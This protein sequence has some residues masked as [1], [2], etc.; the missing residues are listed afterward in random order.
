MEG[1]AAIFFCPGTGGVLEQ[2]P[3]SMA[4]ASDVIS[5]CALDAAARCSEGDRKRRQ[6]MVPLHHA[7]LASRRATQRERRK[8]LHDGFSPAESRESLLLRAKALAHDLHHSTRPDDLLAGSRAA[9]PRRDRGASWKCWNPISMLQASFD[10]KR[11]LRDI[12]KARKAAHGH[13]QKIRNCIAQTYT[14]LQDEQLKSVCGDDGTGA[15]TPDWMVVQHLWD[16]T[17]FNVKCETVGSHSVI[18][19][20]GC[21]FWSDSAGVDHRQE[22]IYAPCVVEDTTAD[23]LFAALS[24]RQLV[25][26]DQLASGAHLVC[27]QPIADSVSANI[28]VVKWMNEVLAPGVLILWGRC[29]QHQCAIAL[30][31]M[32]KYLNIV[33][34]MFCVVKIFYSGQHMRELLKAIEAVIDKRFEWVIDGA[35][36]Q[37]DLSRVK[38]LCAVCHMDIF[39]GSD[40]D[41]NGVKTRECDDICAMVTGD[42]RS[43]KKIS[44]HCRGCCR[45]RD[46]ALAKTVAA[47]TAPLKR[48]MHTPAIN[49][50]GTVAPVVAT[51]LLLLSLHGIIAQAEMYLIGQCPENYAPEES[52]DADDEND[53]REQR[54]GGDMSMASH[55]RQGRRRLKRARE[56][57]C[58]TLTMRNL[59]IWC[60]IGQQAMRLH[61]HLFAHGSINVA[62]DKAALFRLCSLRDS[63]ALQVIRIL[64]TSFFS[65]SP[66]AKEV[67]WG[68][69]ESFYGPMSSWDEDMCEVATSSLNKV[70]GNLWRR[71]FVRLRGWPWKLCRYVDEK[72]PE[73]ER[74]QVAQEFLDAPWCCLD[75]YF[76]RRFRKMVTCIEDMFLGPVVQFVRECFARC[77][78]STTHI[79]NSFAHMRAFLK[80]CRRP[81][82]MPTLGAYH[83]LVEISRTH[84]SWLASLPEAKRTELQRQTGVTGPRMRPMWAASKKNLST[85]VRSNAYSSFTKSR[86]PVLRCLHRK[87]PDEPAVVYK[88][89]LLSLVGKDWARLSTRK[90]LAYGQRSHASAKRRRMRRDDIDTFVRGASTAFPLVLSTAWGLGDQAHP[91]GEAALQR[92]MQRSAQSTES[93]VLSRSNAWKEHCGCAVKGRGDIPNKVSVETP[94]GEICA[95]CIGDLDAETV[96][97]KQDLVKALLTVSKAARGVPN[98]FGDVLVWMRLARHEAGDQGLLV[99]LTSF[100]KAPE[101]SGEYI[102][103]KPVEEE[104]SVLDRPVDVSYTWVHESVSGL[105]LPAFLTETDVVLELI[106]MLEP[107][108]RSM[109]ASQLFDFHRLSFRVCSPG[110]YTLGD[111]ERIDF[112]ALQADQARRAVAAASLKLFTTAMRVPQ[113]GAVEK[114]APVTDRR[115]SR[116]RGGQAA[117]VE[118]S[119]EIADEQDTSDSGGG[120]SADVWAEAVAA[121]DFASVGA[122]FCPAASGSAGNG[123]R[124]ARAIDV[125]RP[126]D[127][128]VRNG[129]T[130]IPWAL[131]F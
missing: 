105:L 36:D 71:F 12:A 25:G 74:K 88:N 125:P 33:G 32:S 11:S 109:P 41:G 28:K 115:R 75:V 27:Y 7:S 119:M 14:T 31:A 59:L 93:F 35:P 29:L 99:V 30:A 64:S 78:A 86:L 94:C 90:K 42:I 97:L 70:I 61:F 89:R 117:C 26:L 16:E 5:R 76:G 98:D 73:E 72:L 17:K 34:S 104:A 45:S 62:K 19:Q 114:V 49:R 20:H 15:S 102:R 66:A 103:L 44:H 120:A 10:L 3:P 39:S 95:R 87:D 46:E 63:R 131:F 108:A 43:W 129:W 128:N 37:D 4:S 82:A 56:W 9:P 107:T 1:S 55:R 100:L 8:K 118:L 126:M 92:E 21:I 110:V 18:S 40:R 67:I 2:S 23:A 13:V 127:V 58:D 106:D 22:L 54:V 6:V 85:H 101:F 47:V 50:W 38:K 84:K 83:V 111:S 48:R 68:L 51:L 91:L 80:S 65:W 57:L 77:L 122:S 60:C 112:G 52:D 81:P 116:V 121:C 123:R 24:R 79:E 113:P 124:R 53:Q 96:K 130:Y 69:A